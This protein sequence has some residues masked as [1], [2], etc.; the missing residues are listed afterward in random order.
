MP[1]H[2]NSIP[3]WPTLNFLIHLPHVLQ[4]HLVADRRAT[5]RAQRNSGFAFRRRASQGVSQGICSLF[6]IPSREQTKKTAKWERKLVFP[7]DM[8]VPGRVYVFSSMPVWLLKSISQIG[9]D[10]SLRSEGVESF[11]VPCFPSDQ[12]AS[13]S[14]PCGG[15]FNVEKYE[16]VRCPHRKDNRF[17]NSYEPAKWE[18]SQANHFSNLNWDDSLSFT[19]YSQRWSTMRLHLCVPVCAAD[20]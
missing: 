2:H 13:I 19:L 10:K 20:C 11:T 5:R 8:S 12:V 14:T 7:W 17:Q 1:S 15:R 4:F 9:G 18:Q 6:L 16:E 3:S